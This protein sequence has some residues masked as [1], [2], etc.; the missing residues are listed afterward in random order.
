MSE[1]SASRS[2]AQRI[3]SR[4]LNELQAADEIG[5]PSVPDYIRMMRRVAAE[6]TRRAEVATRLLPEQVVLKWAQAHI[7][8]EAFIES[9]GGG[10][11]ALQIPCQS[12]DPKRPA[13]FWWI[14]DDCSAPETLG[15][16]AEGSLAVCLYAGDG[17]MDRWVAFTVESMPQ[18]AALIKSYS[19]VQW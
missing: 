14:T 16:L 8:P 3:E 6:C 13:D 5:G 4:A 19:S 2:I 17:E 12:E 1:D 15:R 18:A 11:T 7:H 9:T 10:C